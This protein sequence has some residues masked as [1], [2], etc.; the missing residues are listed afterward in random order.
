LGGF[1][2]GGGFNRVVFFLHSR[3]T[4]GETWS[5]SRRLSFTFVV[6]LKRVFHA[7]IMFIIELVHLFS[8]IQF[9]AEV[10]II[11]KFAAVYSKHCV[12]IIVNL[13]RKYR[14]PYIVRLEV[15]GLC[16]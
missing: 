11:S 5:I 4:V 12:Y 2:P 10:S 15:F 1:R 8:S 16:L 6:E 13:Y 9:F 7:L 14:G 3:S